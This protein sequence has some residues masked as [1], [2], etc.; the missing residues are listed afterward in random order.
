MPT[1]LKPPQTALGV[2]IRER[3]DGRSQRYVEEETAIPPATL[4]RLER[5]TH[6]PSADTARALARWLGWTV[7]QVLDAADQPAQT[8]IQA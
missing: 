2:A 1:P 8:E 7:E 6:R 5:G 4:S 3:R